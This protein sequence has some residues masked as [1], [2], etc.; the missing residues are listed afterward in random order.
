MNPTDLVQHT[1]YRVIVRRQTFKVR[2]LDGIV[3]I[4]ERLLSERHTGVVTIVTSQGG[5]LE[6]SAEDKAKLSEE[7]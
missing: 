5:V 1:T 3:M 4:L 2:S 6:L 7:M